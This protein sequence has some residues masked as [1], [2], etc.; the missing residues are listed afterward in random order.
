MC[1]NVRETRQG[2]IASMNSMFHSDSCWRTLQTDKY[3]NKKNEEEKKYLQSDIENEAVRE[4]RQRKNIVMVW[5]APVWANSANRRMKEIMIDSKV[6]TTKY[7]KTKCEKKVKMPAHYRMRT[8]QQFVRDRQ[9]KNSSSTLNSVESF[10]SV[11]LCLERRRQR[12]RQNDVYTH[13]I[14]SIELYALRRERKM[15]YERAHQTYMKRS[16]INSYPNTNTNIN[17]IHTYTINWN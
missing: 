8:S 5:G 17:R 15:K 10:E 14:D 6:R 13:T 7:W 1:D 4:N 2:Q 16:T 12:R 9:K 11:V 3:E